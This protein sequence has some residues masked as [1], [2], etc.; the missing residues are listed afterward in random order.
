[1]QSTFWNCYQGN[2]APYYIAFTCL[3]FVSGIMC[4]PAETSSFDLSGSVHGQK[5][6]RGLWVT[7]IWKNCAGDRRAIFRAVCQKCKKSWELYFPALWFW[8]KAGQSKRIICLLASLPTC[9]AIS[10]HLYCSRSLLII[11]QAM[12]ASK[13]FT[14]FRKKCVMGTGEVCYPLLFNF[15][16]CALRVWDDYFHAKKGKENSSWTKIK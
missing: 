11:F 13:I 10:H 7:V 5:A 4:H 3:G 15:F 14:D 6:G 12:A 8:S 1:M 9:W 2:K 16:V